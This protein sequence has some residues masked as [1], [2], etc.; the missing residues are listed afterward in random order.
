MVLK[1]KA[2]EREGER[3]REG[4]PH[5]EAMPSNLLT[6][7]LFEL[8]PLACIFALFACIL[9]VVLVLH[10]CTCTKQ[11][12]PKPADKQKRERENK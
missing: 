8:A 11:R 12:K 7:A 10:V 1:E 3:E 6:I 5:G 9:E 4:G 2:R